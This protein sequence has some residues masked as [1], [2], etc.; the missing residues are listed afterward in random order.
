M[1]RW[2]SLTHGSVLD[3]LPR[4]SVRAHCL[5]RGRH[6]MV[7]TLRV[8]KVRS[9]FPAL[10]QCSPHPLQP[11][12]A[13]NRMAS[14]S[15]H[16]WK[17]GSIP[18]PGKHL[19]SGS[20]RRRE[21]TRP[22]LFRVRPTTPYT[23]AYTWATYRSTYWASLVGER[24]TIAGSPRLPKPALLRII[25]PAP[26]TCGRAPDGARGPRWSAYGRTHTHFT[27]PGKRTYAK[28]TTDTNDQ[29]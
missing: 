21:R 19:R 10:R 15:G 1:T 9:R 17:R 5:A 12:P 29:P 8:K 18:T 27:L 25:D 7:K 4:T 22:P 13:P 16:L 20:T 14:A 11:H 3:T 24:C 6:R 26:T 2:R 28:G 23:F